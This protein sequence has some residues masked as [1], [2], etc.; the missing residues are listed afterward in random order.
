MDTFF[1][2]SGLD[3]TT[4]NSSSSIV[5]Y[6]KSMVICYAFY[7]CAFGHNLHCSTL[8]ICNFLNKSLR[9]HKSYLSFFY[10]VTV[11]TVLLQKS[12]FGEPRLCVR[13]GILT[14]CWSVLGLYYL[15]WSS[16]GIPRHAGKNKKIV[17]YTLQ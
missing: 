4:L 15:R 1:S 8:I 6:C 12:R 7:K 10:I 13:C 16:S 2:K 11:N 3:P 14:H 9:V 17:Q 5:L